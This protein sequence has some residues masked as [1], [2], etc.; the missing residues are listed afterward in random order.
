MTD[1]DMIGFINKSNQT[2]HF[3]KTHKRNKM[4][5]KS[6]IKVKKNSQFDEFGIKRVGSTI[7]SGVLSNKTGLLFNNIQF[8]KYYVRYVHEMKFTQGFQTWC[9]QTWQKK[10]ILFVQRFTFIAGLVNY[11]TFTKCKHESNYA[12]ECSCARS[13]LR[14]QIQ[15]NFGV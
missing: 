9:F 6:N 1:T 12:W 13:L 3:I 5:S 10:Y 15:F 4:R 8:N 11:C 14:D 2:D 7:W